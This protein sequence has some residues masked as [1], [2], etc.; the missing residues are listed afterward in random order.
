MLRSIFLVNHDINL[1]AASG[2]FI[3]AGMSGSTVAQASV[4]GDWCDLRSDAWHID[5]AAAAAAAAEMTP[6][7]SVLL[8]GASACVLSSNQSFTLHRQRSPRTQETGLRFMLRHLP[9]HALLPSHTPCRF[10]NS[11][12]AQQLALHRQHPRLLPACC[13]LLVTVPA[14]L[15]GQSASLEL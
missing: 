2:V 9:S 11:A 13:V 1:F 15:F 5:A 8:V 4:L 12:A 3:T 10:K 6:E 14:L 7:A